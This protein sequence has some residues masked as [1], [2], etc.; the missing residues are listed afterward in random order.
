MSRRDGESAVSTSIGLLVAGMVFIAAVG[1]LLMVSIAPGLD[2]EP[3]DAS[4]QAADADAILNVLLGSPGVGWGAGADNLTRLGLAAPG[5]GID[6]DRLLLLESGGTAAAVN[7]HI[8]RDELVAGLGL[9]PAQWGVHLRIG[10]IGDPEP[11]EL[12]ITL[13]GLRAAYVG[14]FDSLTSVTVSLGTE[15][16]MVAEAR[17]KISTLAFANAIRDRQTLAATGLD[18]NNRIHLGLTSPTLL[19]EI[20]PLPAIPLPDLLTDITLLEGDLY[21]DHKQYL[22]DVLPSRLG[23]YDV[24]VVGTGVDHNALTS[25]AVKDAIAAWVDAGGRLVVLGSPQ[26]QSQWMQP[27]LSLSTK[28]GV[29]GSITAPDPEAAALVRPHPLAWQGYVTNGTAWDLAAT[30]QNAHFNDFYH[31]LSQGGYT[32]MALSHDGVFG[33]G[34]VIITSVFLS[35][36]VRNQGAAEA[37]RFLQNLILFHDNGLQVP[38]G[39]EVG[40]PIPDDLPVASAFRT[41][42]GHYDGYGQVALSVEL[43]VWRTLEP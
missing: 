7:G 37:Q 35:E 31:V 12:N 13:D 4:N 24:L 28:G 25:N 1:T 8:D 19:V 6:I 11:K 3:V 16:Q 41:T 9:D 42:R 5:G 36:I 10:V 29:P 17:A 38:T 32:V 26:S 23:E 39:F 27:I 15:E 20:P 2:E 34:N 21:P 40:D 22:N 14:D 30:G 43:L 18:Y 33:N